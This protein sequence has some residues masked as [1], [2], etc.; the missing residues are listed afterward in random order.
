MKPVAS[1]SGIKKAHDAVR[2]KTYPC[3]PPFNTP[4]NIMRDFPESFDCIGRLVHAKFMDKHAPDLNDL[5]MASVEYASKQEEADAA[6]GEALCKYVDTATLRADLDTLQSKVSKAGKSLEASK[7]ELS[8]AESE[9]AELTRRSCRAAENLRRARS[10]VAEAIALLETERPIKASELEER[11]KK[12][13]KAESKVDRINRQLSDNAELI[14]L[15]KQ[16]TDDYATDLYMLSEAK[17]VLEN[18]IRVLELPRF[19]VVPSNDC[20]V[21]TALNYNLYIEEGIAESTKW[22]M[23]ISREFP[24]LTDSER[25]VMG[26]LF[27]ILRSLKGGYEVSIDE[28]LET[29][30]RIYEHFKGMLKG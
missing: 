11:K 12:L 13:A 3:V 19:F 24:D 16:S 28:S 1:D 14:K 29:A 17:A 9:R 22:S 23:K 6:V 30:N 8:N 18:I 7:S 20:I 25:L 21:L 2:E 15:Y 10:A 27:A 5:A 4:P 26:R